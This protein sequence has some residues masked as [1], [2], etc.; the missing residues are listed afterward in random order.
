[1]SHLPQSPPL[2]NGLLGLDGRGGEGGLVRDGH[3]IIGAVWVKKRAGIGTWTY[4]LA[5]ISACVL[6]CKG[7]RKVSIVFK[8]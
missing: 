8:L 5:T 6:Y 4:Q 1:M 3:L 7:Q 2:T